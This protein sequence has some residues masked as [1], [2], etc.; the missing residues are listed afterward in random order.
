MTFGEE[1]FK[2]RVNQSP[3]LRAFFKTLAQNGSKLTIGQYSKIEQGIQNPRNKEEFDIIISS[4][5]ISDKVLIQKL[6]YLALSNTKNKTFDP[7][8]LPVFLPSEIDTDDKLDK[9]MDFLKESDLP[10]W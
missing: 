5:N 2:I 3:S 4:L 10:D 8:D 6:E 1:I 9:L 7:T